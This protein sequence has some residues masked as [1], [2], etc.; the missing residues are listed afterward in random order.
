M[1]TVSL[2]F[3][4]R[5]TRD[6]SSSTIALRTYRRVKGKTLKHIILDYIERQIAWAE[7]ERRRYEQKHQCTF[8]EWSEALSGQATIADEDD[9]M[10]RLI[11]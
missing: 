5:D 10:E 2:K 3:I 7:A 6:H 1:S 11:H 9:W 8:A 4:P